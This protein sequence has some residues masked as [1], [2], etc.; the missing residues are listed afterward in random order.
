[1][2]NKNNYYGFE[3]IWFGGLITNFSV[4]YKCQNLKCK[5]EEFE[6]TNRTNLKAGMSQSANAIKV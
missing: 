4:M 3:T 1:M 5:I 2:K 6:V